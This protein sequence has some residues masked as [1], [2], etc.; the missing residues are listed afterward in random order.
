MGALGL[1]ARP[2]GRLTDAGDEPLVA[3]VV[4]AFVVTAAQAGLLD[5]ALESVTQQDYARYEL[6]VVDDGSP[7][8]LSARVARHANARCVRQP[9]AGPAMARNLGVRE[10]RGAF[11]VFLDADDLLLPHALS[12]GLAAFAEHPACGMVVGPREDMTYE[13][14][15]VSWD[16]AP[17]PESDDLYRTLLAFDWYIIPPSSCMFRR[18]AVSAVGGFRDPWGADDLDFYLRVLQRFPARCY[19]GPPVTRYRRYPESSSRDGERMLRSVRA[20]YRDQRAYVRGHPQRE[21]AFDLGLARLTAIFQRALVENVEVRLRAGDRAGALR[22]A[23]LLAHEDPALFATALP[24]D[25]HAEARA[26]A[27]RAVAAAPLPV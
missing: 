6:L 17:P 27:A 24:A 16:A 4:A 23:V 7:R 22:S 19:A 25:V 11:H 20:V 1:P 5:E 8:D 15:P 9:N 21:A 14:G 3:V 10:S 13:G 18:E 26:L 2:G 12:T